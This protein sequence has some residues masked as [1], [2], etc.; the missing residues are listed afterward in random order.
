MCNKINRN[1]LE[2]DLWGSDIL[3]HFR[4]LPSAPVAQSSHL[5]LFGG[6]MSILGSDVRPE[7]IKY[8]ELKLRTTKHTS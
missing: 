4:L 3:T 1:F 7:M 8:L 5:F 2:Y 6:G